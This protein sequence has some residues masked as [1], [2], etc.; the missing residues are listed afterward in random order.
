MIESEKDI[1][2]HDDTGKKACFLENLNLCV[3]DSYLECLQDNGHKLKPKRKPK[4]KEPLAMME[5]QDKRID[6]FNALDMATEQIKGLIRQGSEGS[7]E[8]AKL[9]T[10]TH[11][12][13][14]NNGQ[15]RNKP[16]KDY[17]E[18]EVQYHYSYAINL[19]KAYSNT[20][21]V[22]NWVGLGTFKLFQLIRVKNLTLETVTAVFPMTAR[23]TKTYLF[24]PKPKQSIMN[25]GVDKLI[26]NLE[27]FDTA[28]L[29][30][31]QKKRLRIAVKDMLRDL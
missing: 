12:T 13:F 6:S 1:C 15:K 5:P 29:N 18:Q 22:E 25:D 11:K 31:D 30:T 3:H 28:P 23:E 19:V 24:P 9:L 2:I 26:E 10:Q 27:T 8:L 4:P 14:F 7:L 20:L 16:F 21:L 17:I